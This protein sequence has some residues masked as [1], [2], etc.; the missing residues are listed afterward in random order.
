[1]A[2]AYRIDN[3]VGDIFRICL[4]GRNRASPGRYGDYEHVE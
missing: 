2:G 3:I 4:W 1:M